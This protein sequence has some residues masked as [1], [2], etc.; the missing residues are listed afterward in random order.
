MEW[1]GISRDLRGF[2]IALQVKHQE[3]VDQ[4][5]MEAIFAVVNQMNQ[6]K[7]PVLVAS[8]FVVCS[9]YLEHTFI[10]LWTSNSASI[11]EAQLNEVV[12]QIACLEVCSKLL[13]FLYVFQDPR[14]WYCANESVDFL[15]TFENEDCRHCSNLLV[16][17]QWINVI[18]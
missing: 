12:P 15:S 11:T 18:T 10:H 3:K 8:T 2:T 1:Q 13:R 9:M 7:G 5:L 4:I 16:C 6:A 14:F 17:Q